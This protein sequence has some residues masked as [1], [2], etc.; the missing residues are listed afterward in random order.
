MDDDDAVIEAAR[1]IRPYL[2]RLADS[3]ATAA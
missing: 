2:D 1:A 3:P